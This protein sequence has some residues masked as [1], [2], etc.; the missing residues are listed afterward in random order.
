MLSE[1][2]HI[3]ERPFSGGSHEN[4]QR[5]LIISSLSISSVCSSGCERLPLPRHCVGSF[6]S[7]PFV[8]LRMRDST[9]PAGLPVFFRDLL[10][11]DI[12]KYTITL[13][14]LQGILATIVNSP[15]TDLELA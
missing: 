5:K 11:G 2:G 1:E 15:G 4:A 8:A 9:P 12:Y 6:V 13:H 14:F 7:R 3:Q 10:T